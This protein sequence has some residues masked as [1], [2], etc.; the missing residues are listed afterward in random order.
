M[1]FHVK[2]TCYQP[3]E[4]IFLETDYGEKILILMTS[5]E[6]NFFLLDWISEQ[7]LAPQLSL[8]ASGKKRKSNLCYNLGKLH[9]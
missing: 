7:H 5:R 3:D 4:F 6:N 2:N 1:C 9:T 8:S